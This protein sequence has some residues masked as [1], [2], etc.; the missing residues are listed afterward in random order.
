MAVKLSNYSEIGRG[1]LKNNMPCQ[2]FSYS[3]K[4]DDFYISVVCDGAGSCKYSQYG[5][6]IVAKCVSNLVCRCFDEL[7]IINEY[8]NKKY[9][10]MLIVS[11]VMDELTNKS[12]E[13]NCDIK[14]LSSTLLFVAVKNGRY[15]AGHIGDGVIGIV[16]NG[17]TDV[18]SYPDNGEYANITY[19]ITGEYAIDRLRTYSGLCDDDVRGFILMT[20][21]ASDSIYHKRDKTLAKICVKLINCLKDI[22]EEECCQFLEKLLKE[23]IVKRTID[24][25]SIALMSLDAEGISK[26]SKFKMGQYYYV[27][28]SLNNVLNEIDKKYRDYLYNIGMSYYKNRDLNNAKKYFEELLNMGKNENTEEACKIL[29][30]IY[31]NLGNYYYENR[32]YDKA[33]DYYNLSSK[34]CKEIM[35]ESSHLVKMIKNKT[36]K[37]KF[38][39]Y[40]YGYIELLINH[41][42]ILLDKGDFKGAFEKFV[43][44]RKVMDKHKKKYKIEIDRDIDRL[45]KKCEDRLNKKMKGGKDYR[46]TKKTKRFRKKEINL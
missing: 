24:D 33:R 14:E 39:K 9:V 8:V 6:E 26:F 30:N 21:G 1:H 25:C 32:N 20:D 42:E 27:R 19:F 28:K 22:S 45:I 10:S 38:V 13:L 16:K 5:A 17:E 29:T 11:E 41:G 23:E 46:D 44:A 15:L 43:R 18:L 34:Y 36:S 3:F 37:C 2:D 12:K 31:Y 35:C 7:Y 4:K 40:K